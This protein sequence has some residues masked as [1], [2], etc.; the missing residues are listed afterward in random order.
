MI[1]YFCNYRPLTSLDKKNYL[2]N[3]VDV[4]LGETSKPSKTANISRS[5][6]P[7]AGC[8]GSSSNPFDA[9]RNF[10]HDD[11]DDGSEQLGGCEKMGSVMFALPSFKVFV[12][13]ALPAPPV[14]KDMVPDQV[15]DPCSR[16]R[17]I[18][19]RTE[20]ENTMLTSLLAITNVADIGCDRDTD[21]SDV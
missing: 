20:A 6:P 7:V 19:V 17:S 21:Y 12:D 13:A 9:L 18:P 3:H 11:S 10:D 4:F 5:I 1:S 8:S 14:K 2:L 15:V 16:V